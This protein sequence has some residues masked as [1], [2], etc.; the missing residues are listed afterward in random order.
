[1]ITVI[2]DFWVTV[3]KLRCPVGM[4]L[5]KAGDFGA[6]AEVAA[7]SGAN[8]V[9]FRQ[10]A[11]Q[12]MA[13]SRYVGFTPDTLLTTL[14]EIQNCGEPRKWVVTNFDLAIARLKLADRTRLWSALVS[15]VTPN[16]KTTI[17]L[18]M[19]DEE[20]AVHLLPPGQILKDWIQTGRALR[21]SLTAP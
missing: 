1:M 7:R 4:L 9:D 10:F 14:R 13:G 15:Q 3:E 21:V 16:S 19:P 18:A 20:T 17:V 5:F 8:I 2:Q 12:R 11:R 6:V